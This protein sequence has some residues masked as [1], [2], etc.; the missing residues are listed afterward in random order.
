MAKKAVTLAKEHK[1]LTRPNMPDDSESA[2]MWAWATKTY[3]FEGADRLALTMLCHAWEQY[4][5]LYKG[6]KGEEK[7]GRGERA[8]DVN[9]CKWYD[10]VY[11]LMICLGMTPSQRHA[12][13]APPAGERLE[14]LETRGPGGALPESLDDTEDQE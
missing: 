3:N 13:G 5:A 6:L 11:K 8:S 2:R 1:R 9:V 7:A 10:R 14:A 12:I 4:C